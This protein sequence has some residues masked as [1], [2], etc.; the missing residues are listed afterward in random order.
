MR[1]GLPLHFVRARKITGLERYA[2]SIAMGA[3]ECASPDIDFEVLASRTAAQ[4]LPRGPLKV[5]KLPGD[6]RI[7]GEQVVLPAWAEW[8]HL[9]L[10]HIPAFGGSFIRRV[11]YVITLLDTVFWDHPDKLSTLGA[12]YYKPMVEGAL[13]SRWHRATIFLSSAARDDAL[14]LF[15][16][17]ARSAYVG[18]CA[19]TLP[20]SAVGRS[21]SDD[22]GDSLRIVS[23][24][25]LEPRKNIAGMIRAVN[26]LREI[27]GREVVWQ[28]VGRKAWITEAEASLLASSNCDWLGVVSDVELQ[29]LYAQSHLFLSL[30]FM[31]GFNIPLVEAMGQGTPAVVSDLPVHREVGDG[32]ALYVD[33]GDPDAAARALHRL[34]V[35]RESWL[36]MSALARARARQFTPAAL[37]ARLAEVYRAAA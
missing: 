3:A 32:G 25:T 15:P 9:D 34:A 36:E 7:F 33:P 29:A 35:D 14:R 1:V 31:E 23:V 12:R 30:S 2:L 26:R 18:Y 11:P 24:G 17:L 6:W 5:T 21:W 37:A 28:H 13:R 8:K 16:H 20:P 10:L 22:R 27:A 4:H 19:T